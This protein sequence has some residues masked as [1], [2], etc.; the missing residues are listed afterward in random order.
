MK[1]ELIDWVPGC[2]GSAEHWKMSI[3][4][5]FWTEVQTI[6]FLLHKNISNEAA[7]F[8]PISGQLIMV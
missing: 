1:Q 2:L 6:Y 8:V 4:F 5:R 3:F 7:R